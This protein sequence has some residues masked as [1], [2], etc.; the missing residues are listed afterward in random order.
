MTLTEQVKILN[1]KIK[2]N[3]AQYDLDREAA[4]ISALSSGELEKYEYLTGEDLG[5]KP[6]VV[7]KAKFEHS[8]L[9]KVFNK[10][11]DERDKKEGI[12]KRLKN[13]EGK[14]KEQ[15]DAQSEKQLNVIKDH[16]LPIMFKDEKNSV[17][18][19]SIF[20]TI[21]GVSKNKNAEKSYKIE[22]IDEK[23]NIMIV[24]IRS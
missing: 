1:G 12:L 3:K 8:P 24:I 16:G 6:G 5:Y 21:A 10:G 19:K 7:V 17:K 18:N 4:K 22:E 14:N 15:L 9:G 2:A 11:L 13:I 23:M 20:E